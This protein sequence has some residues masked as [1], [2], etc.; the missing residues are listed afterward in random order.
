MAGFA[1]VTPAGGGQ[2]PQPPGNTPSH[3]APPGLRDIFLA[4]TKIGLTSFGGGLSGWMMR[5]FVQNRRWLSEGEFLSGLALSQAFP[6]IN[7]V[8]LSIWIGYRL[9]GGWGALAGAGG[10]VVPA[11]LVAI[12]AAAL[13][14]HL[15][16]NPAIH[17][18]MPG[19]AAAAIGLSLQTGLR[20]GRNAARSLVPALILAASFAGIGL[21]RLPLLYVVLVLAPVS[22]AWAAHSLRRGG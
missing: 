11:M 7:T 10:M 5:E 13:F 20:A 12:A 9:R 6:G 8:N 18:M 16:Q 4:F 21:L 2:L 1:E 22:I 17:A 19:V 14:R 3:P 15:S